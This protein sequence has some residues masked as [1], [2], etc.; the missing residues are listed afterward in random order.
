MS[1]Q[2]FTNRY[3]N[4]HQTVGDVGVLQLEDVRGLI[5]ERQKIFLWRKV[6]NV[7]SL[8]CDLKR[9]Q[10]KKKV[11]E[12]TSSYLDINPFEIPLLDLKQVVHATT[13]FGVAE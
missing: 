10:K 8:I 3:Q 2:H 5:K 1:E 6:L 4:N 7:Q 13:S 11:L 9:T 12:W